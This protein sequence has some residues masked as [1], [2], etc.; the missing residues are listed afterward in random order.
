VNGIEVRDDGT[1]SA[2][3]CGILEDSDL[4]LLCRNAQRNQ[5]GMKLAIVSQIQHQNE[6]NHTAMSES[7]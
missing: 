4:G 6:S 3:V 1:N 2:R 5:L 7:V